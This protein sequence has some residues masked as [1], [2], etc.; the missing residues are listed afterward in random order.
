MLESEAST[1]EPSM[2]GS[3][4]AFCPLAWSAPPSQVHGAAAKAAER[5]GKTKQR[6]L[7]LGGGVDFVRKVG[8]F[9]SFLSLIF[10]WEQ[11]DISQKFLR[12]SG[13]IPSEVVH[14]M[15]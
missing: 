4:S 6:Q 8:I 13:R 14:T 7:V 10:L 2:G 1:F 11:G 5:E 9:L 3:K 12:P 15:M